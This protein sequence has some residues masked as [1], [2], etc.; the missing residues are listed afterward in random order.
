[1]KNLLF[2]FTFL[3]MS[4]SGSD[5]NS[6]TNNGNQNFFNPPSWIQ[7]RWMGFADGINTGMGFKFTSDNWCV[8]TGNSTYCWKE[9]MEAPGQTATATEQVSDTDYIVTI[10]TSNTTNVYHFRKVSTTQIQI[11]QASGLNP[12]Y[13]KV[14]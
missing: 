10:T 11:L 5:D 4:C 12:T 3:L 2:I 8:I 6:S 13:T 14:N 9:V 7:G 1:M